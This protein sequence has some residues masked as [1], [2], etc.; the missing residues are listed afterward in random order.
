MERGDG[1]GLPGDVHR[2]PE[3]AHPLLFG[4]PAGGGPERARAGADAG[5]YPVRRGDRRG[6]AGRLEAGHAGDKEGFRSG[7]D[8]IDSIDAASDG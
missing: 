2:R 1:R 7:G 6:G 5:R 3:G 8:D 4:L